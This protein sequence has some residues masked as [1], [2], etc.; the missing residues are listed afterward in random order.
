MCHVRIAP[1]LKYPL[2]SHFRS[3]RPPLD[4]ARV[5]GRPHDRAARRADDAHEGQATARHGGRV[6]HVA[7]ERD[8][9]RGRRHV[10]R[11]RGERTRGA[12]ERATRTRGVLAL[13]IG[14]ADDDDARRGRVGDRFASSPFAMT[15]WS[16]VSCSTARHGGCVARGGGRVARVVVVA[17]RA[18]ARR[19]FFF[20][21]RA[22]AICRSCGGTARATRS[23]RSTTCGT[24]R[25]RPK[26]CSRAAGTSSRTSAARATRRSTGSSAFGAIRR[27]LFFVVNLGF[28]FCS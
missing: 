5:P 9:D 26:T 8:V 22:A 3:T 14:R 13:G 19:S 18:R 10:L 25:R 28:W 21:R 16:P 15:K 27:L 17:L 11:R 6:R 20:L 12:V 23:S 1:L 24:L 7:D 4:H 2:T